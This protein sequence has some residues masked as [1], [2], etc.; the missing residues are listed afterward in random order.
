LLTKNQIVFGASHLKNNLA[1]NIIEEA[2][3]LFEKDIIIPALINEHNGNLANVIYGD[4]FSSIFK[5]YIGWDLRDNS[6]WFKE[7]ILNGFKLDKSLLRNNLKFTKKNN[8]NEI[9]YFLETMDYFDR[10]RSNGTIR[11]LIHEKDIVNYEKYR[12][13]IYNT[14]G[15]RVVN[16]ESSLDQKNMIHDYSLT[17]INNRNISSYFC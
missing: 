4:K 8:I 1:I 10:D 11:D 17:D 14:S 9:I 16:C 5:S 7:Q 2:P 3:F 12:N 13:L 15:A 6:D